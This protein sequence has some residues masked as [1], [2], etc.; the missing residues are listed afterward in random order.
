ME[1]CQI[2][3]QYYENYGSFENSNWKPKGSFIFN[4]KVDTDDF[5]YGESECVEAIKLLLEEQ[6][7]LHERF[8]YVS[9]ELIFNDIVELDSENFQKKLNF[10]IENRTM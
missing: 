2:T 4:L 3:T 9:H 7:N 6:S 1:L 5:M 8:S 10:I